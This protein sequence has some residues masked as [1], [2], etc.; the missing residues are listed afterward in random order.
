MF[1]LS[2]I[3]ALIL[4]LEELPQSCLITSQGA[5]RHPFS[6]KNPRTQRNHGTGAVTT[7]INSLWHH[8]SPDLLIYKLELLSSSRVSYFAFCP[9]VFLISPSPKM[10][11]D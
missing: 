8:P 5:H 11:W 1:K 7:D 9:N 2:S 4:H 6:V 10:P 3:Y